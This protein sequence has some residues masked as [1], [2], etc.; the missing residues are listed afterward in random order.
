M[1]SLLL[2]KFLFLTRGIFD[3]QNDYD[4]GMKRFREAGVSWERKNWG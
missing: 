1:G 2:S 4:K 3:R